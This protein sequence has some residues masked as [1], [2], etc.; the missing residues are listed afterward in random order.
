FQTGI[1][2]FFEYR[3]SAKWLINAGL[4]L[5]FATQNIKQGVVETFDNNGNLSHN[6]KRNE[7]IN[8]QYYNVSGSIGTNYILSHHH[9]FKINIGSAYR[10]PAV[11]E[12]AANGVH[13]GTFRHEL[14]NA[15]LNPE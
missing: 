11:V 10:I 3:P 8:K 5:D 1:S 9:Q 13:H 7:A 15:Y 6:E 2:N 14:G 4:R 12:L